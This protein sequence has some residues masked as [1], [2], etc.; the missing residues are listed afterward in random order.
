MFL[1]FLQC[2]GSALRESSILYV[3][4]KRGIHVGYSLDIRRQAGHVLAP[5]TRGVA[6][7]ILG[8]LGDVTVA[9]VDTTPTTFV[10]HGAIPRSL[11]TP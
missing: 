6:K 3:D 11:T 9:D 10:V 4:S 7:V 5:A 1:S 2:R 8:K